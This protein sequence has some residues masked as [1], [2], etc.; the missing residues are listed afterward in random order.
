MLHGICSS[1]FSVEIDTE[2]GYQLT[3]DCEE[4]A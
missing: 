2:K 1:P 3:I 4:I